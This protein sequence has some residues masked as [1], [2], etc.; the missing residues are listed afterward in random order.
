M[1]GLRL[2][3][4]EDAEEHLKELRRSEPIT[5]TTEKWNREPVSVGS[6]RNA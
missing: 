2:R 6:T 4:P 3:S 5:G 1:T